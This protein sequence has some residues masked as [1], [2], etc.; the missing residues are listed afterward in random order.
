MTANTNLKINLEIQLLKNCSRQFCLQTKSSATANGMRQQFLVNYHSLI[1]ISELTTQTTQTSSLNVSF[2]PYTKGNLLFY[3]GNSLF[4]LNAVIAWSVC[5]QYTAA[6]L[7]QSAAPRNIQH[8]QDKSM[9]TA[10]PTS[11][12][13]LLLALHLAV[14]TDA[15]AS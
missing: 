1:R 9:T 15:Q 4:V 7:E 2:D 6:Q 12:L 14:P 8:V 11:K 5:L 3:Q 10:I 13:L